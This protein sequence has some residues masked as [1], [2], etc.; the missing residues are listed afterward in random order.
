[1][2]KLVLLMLVLA[3]AWVGVNY[4]RT[5]HVS[6]FPTEMSEEQRRLRDLE[7]ELA[8]VNDQIA[9]AGRAAGLTGMDT[10]ADVEALLKRKERLEKRIAEVRKDLR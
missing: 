9:A 6:L 3:G 4:V 5:G 10:T 1:M 2:K 7:K 8:S